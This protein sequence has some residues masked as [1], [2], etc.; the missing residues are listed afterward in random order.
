MNL[1][2]PTVDESAS[3]SIIQVKVQNTAYSS[4][5]CLIQWS[6]SLICCFHMLVEPTGR[7]DKY[8]VTGTDRYTEYL[9]NTAIVS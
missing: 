8:Y 5:V 9:V 6:N 1:S 4:E 3:S 2:I 7:Q